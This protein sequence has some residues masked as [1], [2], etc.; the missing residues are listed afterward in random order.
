LAGDKP[1]T[2]GSVRSAGW[3][4]GST[5]RKDGAKKGYAAPGRHKRGVDG[6]RDF[7]VHSNPL[8]RLMDGV[9]VIRPVGWDGE[10]SS[11]MPEELAENCLL[12]TCRFGLDPPARVL[13]CYGGSG[14][15]SAVAKRLGLRSIYIDRHQPFV[16]EAKRRVAATARPDD[17]IANENQPPS[18]TTST[19]D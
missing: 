8:G 9:W 16:Q 17:G 14:T 3:D 11:S 1:Y 6:N 10:H 18:P 2:L 15:V 13:D 12:L 5:Y 19:A 7:R 4:G